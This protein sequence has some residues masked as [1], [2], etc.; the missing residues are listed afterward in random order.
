MSERTDRA[1]TLKTANRLMRQSHRLRKL[2][3]A[4]LRES[5]DD[6]A[7]GNRLKKAVKRKRT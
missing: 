6:R 1:R 5:A 4:L 2:A 3:E 7:Q